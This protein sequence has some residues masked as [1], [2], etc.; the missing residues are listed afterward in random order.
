[1]DVRVARD[2][3]RMRDA[4]ARDR[5][6]LK[7]ISAFR[8]MQDQEYFYCK[9]KNGTGNPAA[10]PGHSKHQ[11]GV[12]LDLNTIGFDIKRGKGIVY[13]W[14]AKNGATYG[15]KR[16]LSEHWHWEHQPSLVG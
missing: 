7:I 11:S 6:P 3:I 8:T 1:M 15:F 10:K 12:A 9:Y 4:A 2:F 13:D 5:V 16:I 14:L